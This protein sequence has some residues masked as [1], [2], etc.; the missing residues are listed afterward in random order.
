M[1]PRTHPSVNVQVTIAFLCELFATIIAREGPRSGVGASMAD[2]RR[3]GREGALAD[4]ARH[5]KIESACNL[6]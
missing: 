3:Q 5:A 1:F 6:A 2:R 4:E